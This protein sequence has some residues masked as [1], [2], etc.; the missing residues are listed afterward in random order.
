[1]VAT[2]KKRQWKEGREEKVKELLGEAAYKPRELVSP[3]QADKVAKDKKEALKELW[4]K[5]AGSTA[6]VRDSDKRPAIV[7]S[8]AAELLL[9]ADFLQ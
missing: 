8:V 2:T 4:E 5:P 3:S 7:S 9:A 1:M 6:L